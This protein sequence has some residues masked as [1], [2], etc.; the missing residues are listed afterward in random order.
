MFQVNATLLT[1]EALD[2]D[3]GLNGDIE[4]SFTSKTQRNYGL[5][6]G[7]NPTGGQIYLRQTL[8]ANDRALYPL[9]VVAEDQGRDVLSSIVKVGSTFSLL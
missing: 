2:S 6:F 7:I 9:S 4:Y 8:N 1:V 5:I 3:S